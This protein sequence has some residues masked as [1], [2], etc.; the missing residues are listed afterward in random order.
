MRKWLLASAIMLAMQTQA[1]D[2]EEFIG[3]ITN[4][5][6][7][8]TGNVKIGVKLAD[9]EYLSCKSETWPFYFAANESYSKSWIDMVFQARYYGS[10][11]RIGYTPS[12]ENN[13]D[14]EYLAMVSDDGVD[15]GGGDTN[16]M[17]RTGAYGN[18][19]LVNTNS[20][21]ESSYSASDYY[22]G[23]YPAAAFDGY[24]YADKI[25]DDA[26]E[27]ISRGIWMVKKEV[28]ESTGLN[29]DIWL[30]ISYENTVKLT[31]MRFMINAKSLKLGRLPRNI[32]IQG[33]NDGS[34]FT[35]LQSVQLS[36]LADQ[37]VSFNAAIN[38]Q[39]LRLLVQNNFGDDFVEI[40][41][42]ELYSE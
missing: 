42:I 6:L 33:S 15:S 9:E 35:N 12:E 5:Y 37:G 10:T 23:D 14:I 29:K 28:D 27:K 30:Q 20:L 32:I 24:M 3:K 39:H 19:A 2:T 17:V 7:G 26:D 11:L 4:I 36:Q 16:S 21:T 38:V 31:G 22:S 40:D 34:N 18:V 41:E 8:K 1:A 13:C 25:N